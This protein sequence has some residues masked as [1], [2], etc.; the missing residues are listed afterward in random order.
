MLVAAQLYAG[1]NNVYGADLSLVEKCDCPTGYTGLSC[2][3]CA[4]GF[5]RIYENNTMH[6]RIGK[7]IQCACN[8]HAAQCDPI[9]D[10]CGKCLHNT[11][12]DR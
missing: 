8:G 1:Q 9:L 3:R 10:K 6:E 12:G 11:Y 7:C 2:E 5:A 4:F